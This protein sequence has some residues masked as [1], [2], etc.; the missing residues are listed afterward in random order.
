MDI[1][2]LFQDQELPE[3]ELQPGAVC[4]LIPGERGNLPAMLYTPGGTGPYPTVLLAH[5]YPGCEQNMDLAQALR[6][7]GFAVMT[8][9]YS[10]SWGADGDFSFENCLQDTESILTCLMECREKWNLDGDNFFMVGHSMGGFVAAHMLARYE[11]LKAGVLITPFDVG[12]LY[13]EGRKDE[14][15]RR[16]LNDVLRCG[17][18][19]LRGYSADNLMNEL[20][21]HA[22]D[23]RLS[24]LTDA[25]SQ[26]PILCIGATRDEDTPVSLHCYPLCE[27]MERVRASTFFYE[28]FCTNHT[29][30]TRRITLCRD[31]AEFLIHFV[32]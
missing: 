31:V 23:F 5:G 24:A 2:N 6:R 29:L 13:L 22:R 11:E 26:K 3:Y 17:D 12:R 10:G 15:C 25:L 9:H 30:A 27:A 20:S 28:E 32:N 18:G 1:P 7:V 16:S 14:I 21:L 19:W 8:Y 4:C